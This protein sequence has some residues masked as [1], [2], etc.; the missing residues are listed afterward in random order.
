MFRNVTKHGVII[1][2]QVLPP[3]LGSTLSAESQLDHVPQGCFSK[4]ILF[5]HHQRAK[6][7][8]PFRSHTL[9][10]SFSLGQMLVCRD[11]E[12]SGMW[13]CHYLSAL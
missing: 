10:S 1:R 4:F 3:L 5:S 7:D 9:S 13:D 11:I 8:D 12:H 6:A 2:C